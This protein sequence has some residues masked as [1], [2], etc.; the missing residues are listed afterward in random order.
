MGGRLRWLW[1]SGSP[2]LM[3]LLCILLFD[4]SV[5][6]FIFLQSSLR[7]V[8]VMAS[9]PPP[10]LPLVED[11]KDLHPS[12]PAGQQYYAQ[13]APGAAGPYYGAPY[14]PVAAAPTQQLIINQAPPVIMQPFQYVRSY[15]GHIVLACFVFLFCGG[16]FGLIAFILAG[17][18]RLRT[19]FT[20]T[21]CRTSVV[22]RKIRGGGSGSV[23]SIHQTVS[24][25]SK[26]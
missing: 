10:Y 13:P 7:A 20:Q 11:P 4:E 9:S 21:Q 17:N 14:Q 26:N 8:T 22:T 3:L 23:R 12:L 5:M 1:L 15:C 25:T 2:P 16:L 18:W 24:G 6:V 19:A